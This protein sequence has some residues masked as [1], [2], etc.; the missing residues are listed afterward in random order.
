[1][2]TLLVIDKDNGKLTCQHY[3]VVSF[4]GMMPTGVTWTEYDV[5]DCILIENE[6]NKVYLSSIAH[7][8]KQYYD[9]GDVSN[10]TII[11][12]LS[13][14][15]YVLAVNGITVV[16]PKPTHE[17]IVNL[18][19]YFIKLEFQEENG[20]VNVSSVGSYYVFRSSF[21]KGQGETN[22]IEEISSLCLLYEIL[23]GGIKLYRGIVFYTKDDEYKTFVDDLNE[24]SGI[25]IASH[26]P[27]RKKT[28]TEDA[29]E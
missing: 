1:M 16:A 11:N 14:L 4:G 25:L 23:T 10:D 17:D 13:N 27:S 8:V 21:I 22:A 24:Y 12:L 20:I 5:Q 19:E 15:R 3:P 9:R 26:M 28:D 18:K 6:K 2:A 29:G 7:V